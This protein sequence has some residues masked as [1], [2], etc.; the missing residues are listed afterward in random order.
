MVEPLAMEIHHAVLVRAEPEIVFDALTKPEELDSWFTT[1][2][3]VDLRPGGHILFR[4][5]DWGPDKFNGEDG[6]PILEAERPNRFVF[7]WHPYSQEFP[8]TV[9]ITLRPS[10]RGTILALTET[11]YRDTPDGR[12]AFV[13][14]ATGWGEALTLLKFFVEHGIRY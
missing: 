3:E 7:Q 9:H 10:E 5:V 4:W 6:G 8:T 14:C 1:G 11:G 2:A 12:A 13:D